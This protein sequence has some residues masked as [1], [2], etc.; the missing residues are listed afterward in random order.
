[1]SIRMKTF[2]SIL[3]ET[4]LMTTSIMNFRLFFVHSTWVSLAFAIIFTNAVSATPP[5]PQNS[6]SSVE[7]PDYLNPNPNPLQSNLDNVQTS[8]VALNQ[9]RE[10]LNLARL[11]FQAGVG[12][13]TEVINAENDLTTAEGNRVT[14]ILNYNIAL[15]NLQRSVTYRASR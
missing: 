8:S 10:A 14:A 9:A 3:K 11:R 1:M 13:Q 5:K 6:S 2:D 7:V 12:T 15:A 4:R